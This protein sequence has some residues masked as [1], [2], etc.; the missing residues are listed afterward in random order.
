MG[1]L[2]E[3]PGA[4]GGE[5]SCTLLAFEEPLVGGGGDDPAALRSELQRAMGRGAGMLR[6]A[7][8]LSGV[9]DIVADLAARAPDP[10]AGSD[11]AELANLLTVAGALTVLAAAR[12]ESRG[13]HAREDFPDT[14][15]TLSRR[16]LVPPGQASGS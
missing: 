13:A 10:S 15:V 16:I 2:Q 14:D 5:V 3:P 4:G 9:V 11:A 12:S 7:E 6:S 1:Q 8:S